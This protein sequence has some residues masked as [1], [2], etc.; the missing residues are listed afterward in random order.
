MLKTIGILLIIIVLFGGTLGDVL[1][2]VQHAVG[3][4]LAW[5]VMVGIWKV[6]G[7]LLLIAV[8]RRLIKTLFGW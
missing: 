3:V 6:I 8:A 1:L 7:I 2:W 4:L 5:V